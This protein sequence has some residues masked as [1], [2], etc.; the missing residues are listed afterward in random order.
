[1]GE[2]Y[3]TND[4]FHGK[5]GD[6]METLGKS[7]NKLKKYILKNDGFRSNMMEIY[8]KNRGKSMENHG[9]MPFFNW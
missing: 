8:R 6:F 7:M 9:N 1:M 5:I 2:I 4:G 3:G